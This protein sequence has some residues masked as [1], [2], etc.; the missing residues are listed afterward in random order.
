MALNIIPDAQPETQLST[1]GAVSAGDPRKT[2]AATV[3]ASARKTRRKAELAYIGGMVCVFGATACVSI[4][5]LQPFETNTAYAFF[6]AG[7]LAFTAGA[8]ASAK[9]LIR[10][11]TDLLQLENVFSKMIASYDRQLQEARSRAAKAEAQCQTMM[12][13]EQR[14][15]RGLAGEADGDMEIGSPSATIGRRIRHNGTVQ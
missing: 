1:G 8:A 3:N 11:L 15:Q 9:Y 7:A 12:R 13:I 2:P 6:A 10:I 4:P 14:R 5:F